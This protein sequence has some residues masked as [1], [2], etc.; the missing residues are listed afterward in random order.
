MGTCGK[1]C[2]RSSE[3]I[4]ILEKYSLKDIQEL[5]AMAWKNVESFYQ[6]IS[7][8][9][10]R[11]YLADASEME[12]EWNRSLLAARA[13]NSSCNSRSNRSVRTIDVS[14]FLSFFSDAPH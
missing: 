4:S 8:R 7:S 12:K 14:S 6:W 9:M 1:G 3:V 13:S 2:G 5:A 10:E 11:R